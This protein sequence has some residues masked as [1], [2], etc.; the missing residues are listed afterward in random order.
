MSFMRSWVEINLDAIE[1]NTRAIAHFV[2]PAQVIA[3]LKGDAYGHGLIPCAKA[4]R[5]GG[6]SIIAVGDL[7]EAR[8]LRK[9]NDVERILVLPPILDSEI[10]ELLYLGVEVGI[11]NFST[12]Q[13]V[14]KKKVSANLFANIHIF[15]DTGLGREGFSPHEIQPLLEVLENQTTA[16]VVGVMSHLQS[17]HDQTLANQ[18]L[19]IFNNLSQKYF[20]GIFRHLANS[21]GISLG[22][23]FHLDAVRVGLAIFGISRTCRRIFS[24]TH[25]MTWRSRIGE[26]HKRIAG[27]IVGYP[28]GFYLERETIIGLLPLGYSGGFP[29][30]DTGV[31]WVRG[32]F[33]PIIGK[34]NMSQMMIDLTDIPSAELG[35]IVTIMGGE[36]EGQI[37]IE[38][39]CNT[40]GLPPN[41]FTCMLTPVTRRIYT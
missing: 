20:P 15:F 7:H 37:T 30:I 6:A 34:I 14:R 22:K 35:D 28:P 33:A 16:R 18:Q 3:V 36:N 24:L 19:D 5:Q 38:Q 40:S 2:S 26:I 1:N 27:S 4:V 41:L 32:R 25:A 13:Y 21:G 29:P 31:V 8:L 17:S 10:D 23:D 9:A 39:L 11:S 12:L